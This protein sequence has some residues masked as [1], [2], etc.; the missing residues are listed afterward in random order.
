MLRI[1]VGHKGAN[2][3]VVGMLGHHCHGDII[4]MV[5]DLENMQ[6]VTSLTNLLVQ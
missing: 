2:L 3:R 4:Q 1:R 6:E 5:N